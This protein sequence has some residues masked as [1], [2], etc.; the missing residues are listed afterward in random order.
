MFFL[1]CRIR[2]DIVSKHFRHFWAWGS[3]ELC[4]VVAKKVVVEHLRYTQKQFGIDTFAFEN[5][6]H[7]GA[8]A[9]DLCSKPRD[10]TPL[11]AKFALYELSYVNITFHKQ[12]NASVNLLT[13]RP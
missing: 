5:S 13:L 10:T 8:F 12:K 3:L 9:T 2:F 4:G 11:S 1:W 6:V 7:I